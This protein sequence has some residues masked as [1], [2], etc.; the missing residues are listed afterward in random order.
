MSNRDYARKSKKSGLNKSLIL[1][2]IVVLLI[3]SGVG[4]WFLKESASPSNPIPQQARPRTQQKSTLPSPP[5]EVY[6]YIRDLE[7]REVP[8]DSGS[9]FS[10][11]TQEQEQKMLKQ[12]EKEEERRRL[13]QQEQ[14]DKQEEKTQSEQALSEQ[15]P[16]ERYK[17][18]ER[19]KQAAEIRKQETEAKKRDAESK[20]VEQT[21]ST[22]VVSQSSSQVQK[23]SGKFGLQCGA[24]KNKAQ[25]EN[26][27]AR[28]TMAGY[29]AQIATNAD[30]NRVF[31]GPI[32]DRAAAIKAQ[33]NAKSVAE[34]VIVS[35]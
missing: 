21:K 20:N 35:M 6:S 2:L 28:L 7:T 17:Q 16:T 1:A 30:W 10:Q 9:Q 19:Q 14:L 15:D 25:A 4:L 32:G 8:I 13:L 29:N 11:L 22:K 12:K 3:A 23:P 26:M 24:F 33:S 18:A 34:C 27:Q 5:E 31:I